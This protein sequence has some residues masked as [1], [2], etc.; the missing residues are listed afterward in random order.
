MKECGLC[1]RSRPDDNLWC[2]EKQCPMEDAPLRLR[3]G[4]RM[5]EME[6]V[7]WIT[8][9]PAATLYKARRGAAVVLLKVAH[10]GYED[11]LKREALFLTGHTHPVLPQLLPALSGA[12][13]AE[14]PYG[15]TAARGRIVTFAVFD[16]VESQVLREF[17]DRDP[18][19]WYLT[20]GWLVAGLADAL[21]FLNDRGLLHLCL[22][23][24]VV[25]V[26]FDQENV[27]RPV[28]TDLGVA[29]PYEDLPRHWRPAFALPAYAAPEVA[30]GGAVGP[31]TD[32]YGIGR[33]F[34]EMLTGQPPV[35]G[36][37]TA[38]AEAPAVTPTAGLLAE[39]T[40][41]VVLPQLATRAAAADPRRRPA[42]MPLFLQEL[43]AALPPVPRENRAR[44]VRAEALWMLAVAAVLVGLLLL[45]AIIFN[46]A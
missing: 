22:S 9:L 45:A 46:P 13:P 41:L 5:G 37:S 4:D 6:I 17:L 10:P 7:Q 12:S 30:H 29:C 16:Y 32:V 20:T 19:P 28:L 24:E 25:L 2:Q 18:Q 23:P 34:A 26:R 44:V 38:L 43:L 31:A 42:N 35:R 8:T 14:Y 36:V 15:R 27:P 33:L 1:R 40:D 3:A 11:K 39:R 21:A